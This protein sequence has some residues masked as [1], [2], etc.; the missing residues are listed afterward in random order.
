MTDGLTETSLAHMARRHRRLIRGAALLVALAALALLVPAVVWA[1]GELTQKAGTAGCVSEDGTGGTCQDGKAL[2]APFGVATSPDGK[3]VYVSSSAS[4]GAT[5]VAIFDRNTTTG[6]LT[7]KAGTAGCITED[8]TG[9]ACQDGVAL[10]GSRHMSISADGKSVYV[11]AAVSKAVAVFDRNTTTGELTQKSGTDGCISEDGTGGA[12]QDGVAMDQ[13]ADVT[14]S[15]DGKSLYVASQDSSG[16]AGAV[17]I[18]DRDTTTGELTQKSGT[19][20][21]ISE[22]TTGGSCQDGKALDEPLG[23]VTSPDDKNVYVGAFGSGAVAVLD[24]DTTTGELTQK[25][26]T[27]GC[28]SEDGTG[29][30]CQDGKALLGPD[31]NGVVTS[32]DG[33]NLYVASG[34]ADAVA[35][36][37]RDTATGE[38]TQK[39][40]TAGC[41]S[42]DG[43]G[44][45]CQDGVALNST[46]SVVTSPAG[47]SVYVASVD[48][49]GVAILD[50]D[51]TTG[52]LTQKAG[53]DACVADEGALLGCQDGRELNHPSEVAPSPDGRNVY[54][55]GSLS[56]AVAVFDRTTAGPPP[57]PPPPPPTPPSPPTEVPD[58]QDHVDNDADGAIDK[59]DPGCLSSSTG[60]YNAADTNEG[61]EGL[62]ELFLC[63]RRAISLVRADVKG[64][65]VVL[66]GIVSARFAGRRVSILANYGAAKAGRFNQVTTVRPGGDGQFTARVTRPPSRLFVR[67]RF[68][69]RVSRFNS[70]ALKLPQS[71]AS[72]SIKQRGNQLV[73]RGQ[74]KRSVL[75]KRNPVL[76][77]R[78]VCGHYQTVGSVRPNRRGAYTL[79]FPAP[80]LTSAALYRAEAKVLARP[81][82]RRYVKQFA[83]A[84]GITLLQ[85]P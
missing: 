14:V 15:P 51:T 21:C 6:E 66:R 61:D 74:V 18:L 5:G 32:P 59:E 60:T 76:V 70:V 69:A 63:G 36:L 20:G 28:V 68:R 73:L 81:G 82:S 55:S 9:G 30:E 23:V 78:L 72:S 54:V 52:E 64:G 65:R 57:P 34:P 22:D 26:G 71:L 48:Y 27:A 12:C 31:F 75:G 4:L 16:G 37:D 50:R 80:S 3:N 39:A 44:G 79:R 11:A 56:S 49:D 13:P 77:R 67:A 47:E 83:R 53:T 33:K 19:D 17:A 42:E 58:C 84:I 45:A 43:T 24:R 46:N 85:G 7:Q 35:I 2:T 8:G 41:I 25:A 10:V 40:G 62:R 38:L 29:G 1:V